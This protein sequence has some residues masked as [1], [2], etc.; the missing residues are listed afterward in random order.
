MGPEREPNSDNLGEQ[1]SPLVSTKNR[2]KNA[3]II[4]ILR[5]QNPLTLF[6]RGI[7]LA[8][9]GCTAI[10]VSLDSKDALQIIQRLRNELPDTVQIGVGTILERNQ[11][12]ACA[13]AG[14]TFALSPTFPEGMIE[15]CHANDILAIPGVRNLD[16][17]H[18]A[19]NAGAHIVKL[20]PSTE[21]ISEELDDVEIPWIPVGSIDN[22]SIWTWLDAGAWCVGM[23]ANLCGSDLSQEGIGTK[24]WV[25]NEAQLARDIFMELQHRHN[26]T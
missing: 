12:Q 11:I 8:K 17:L 21:W 25:G 7:A 20:F 19:Q 2:L 5:G 22:E 14:A 16:E 23:G 26:A 9:I 6:D 18:I 13:E 24:D 10:E 4:A 1:V 15:D 3:G